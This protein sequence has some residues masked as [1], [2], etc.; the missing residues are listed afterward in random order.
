[1]LHDEAITRYEAQESDV[2]GSIREMKEAVD[3]WTGRCRATLGH[4]KVL[5]EKVAA[6]DG[7]AQG[8][9]PADEHFDVS[10]L[11]L[12]PNSVQLQLN[13]LA[14]S[15][16]RSDHAQLVLLSDLLSTAKEGPGRRST[17]DS[18]L[19][20]GE[21]GGAA[22]CCF[23]ALLRVG[24]DLAAKTDSTRVLGDA[25]M[26]LEQL[27]AS[28]P[29]VRHFLEASERSAALHL[30]AK[31]DGRFAEADQ[32]LADQCA[33]LSE[34]FTLHLERASLLGDPAALE[35]TAQDAARAVHAA[36]VRE[37]TQLQAANA[38]TAAQA[39]ADA[40]CLARQ[41]DAAAAALAAEVADA[42][43]AAAAAQEALEAN[44]GEQ[45]ALFDE[46][47][48]LAARLEAKGAER[49][50]L[51][52][53]LV[54]AE[55]EKARRK[56]ACQAKQALIAE[57]QEKLAALKGCLSAAD[58]VCGE[59]LGAGASRLE[60]LEREIETARERVRGA[61]LEERRDTYARYGDL[62]RQLSERL[63]TG[64]RRVEELTAAAEAAEWRASISGS[65]L[66]H[67]GADG[68]SANHGVHVSTLREAMQ[69]V[70]KVRAGL[71]A[72]TRD[73]RPVHEALVR[74]LADDAP[75]P[76]EDTV[77]GEMEARREE[78]ERKRREN[79]EKIAENVR[80][81][82]RS[83]EAGAAERVGAGSLAE[84]RRRSY[85]ERLA[86][87]APASV[88]RG[89]TVASAA[90]SPILSGGGGRAG[91]AS[92]SPVVPPYTGSPQR[93][94]RSSRG[95]A[96]LLPPPAVTPMRA[97]AAAAAGTAADDDYEG[98]HHAGPSPSPARPPSHPHGGMGAAPVSPSP[99]GS[100]QASLP[101]GCD[102]LRK[103]ADMLRRAAVESRRRAQA[104]RDQ[105]N[106][107]SPRRAYEQAS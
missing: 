29:T 68:C 26:L 18:L 24:G 34:L 41:S 40:A 52:G 56:R 104:H 12:D 88:P 81:N 46:L 107:L 83:A 78:L 95:D 99:A 84:Q 100:S 42:E 75:T 14:K 33:V 60:V 28:D 91:A 74:A 21:G 65:T 7:P 45:Q 73:A 20:G 48:A 43:A 39:D 8:P 82:M 57:H 106:S 98:H 32:H 86:S 31:R 93:D 69:G 53:A 97:A 63:F 55:Q 47:E 102:E 105:A 36:F 66:D 49:R 6:G 70:S 13:S 89:Q 50:E 90:A 44:A 5:M 87:M 80:C 25:A 103:R 54:G 67:A 9:A 61:D 64:E 85:A 92:S 71:A 38:A 58:A 1:M 77:P 94:P 23:S 3:A 27:R 72:A 19:S 2:V 22:G 10:Q 96:K 15:D 59:M 35:D 4:T 51:C 30:A 11:T 17:A 62:Y 101:G 37:V 76:P 79:I 16:P